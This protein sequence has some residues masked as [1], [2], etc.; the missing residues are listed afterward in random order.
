M[1]TS[2]VHHPS[3]SPVKSANKLYSLSTPSSSEESIVHSDTAITQAM[4]EIPLKPLTDVNNNETKPNVKNVLQVQK[5]ANA[6]FQPLTKPNQAVARSSKS[7]SSNPLKGA[8]SESINSRV[9]G[10]IKSLLMTMQENVHALMSRGEALDSIQ[11][12][13]QTLA[14]ASEKFNKTATKAERKFKRQNVKWGLLIALGVILII[15]LIV[16]IG[17]LVPWPTSN[18]FLKK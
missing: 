18:P 1:A 12:K 13:T 7:F 16:V 14:T 8:S 11:Q 6:P 15:G 17:A 2:L 9:Q 10:Q 4:T 5:D 3:I